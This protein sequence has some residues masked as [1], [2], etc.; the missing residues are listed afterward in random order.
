MF[1]DLLNFSLIIIVLFLV[2]VVLRKVKK[3]HLWTYEIKNELEEK[4]ENVISQI[5]S[6]L[7]LYA[8]LELKK[9]IPKTRGWAGSP[10]F[11]WNIAR[12]AQKNKPRVVVECS[13]GVSTVVLAQSLKLNGSGHVYSMDHDP[14]FA[15]KTRQELLRHNLED[16][17]T[18][19]DAPITQHHIADKKWPWYS[20]E[21]L[22]DNFS[23]DMLVI[24]GPPT[25]IGEFARYPAG[26]LLFDKLN[27]TGVVFLDDAGRESEKDVLARW[28]IEFSD[29]KQVEISCEKGCVYLSY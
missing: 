25:H 3:I 7:G 18:V 14:V 5:E 16:W 2:L 27:N 20:L 29:L 28:E 23:I 10:D 19:V 26:P 9:S 6:L 21:F 13:S 8:D 15:E 1:L 17:A 12:L 24:D 11:L 22:P 4:T